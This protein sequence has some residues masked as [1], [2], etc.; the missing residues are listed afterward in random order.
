MDDYQL[1]QDKYILLCS[2]GTDFHLP[3]TD[4]MVE[5]FS[6]M[7]NG[8]SDQPK[9]LAKC[10]KIWDVLNGLT[11]E[12]ELCNYEAAEIN[13]FAQT[14]SKVEVYFPPNLNQ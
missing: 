2:D 4:E 6:L 13:M 10:I 7:D 1:Y 3:W 8:L 14:W 9:C 12:T 5:E 11:I